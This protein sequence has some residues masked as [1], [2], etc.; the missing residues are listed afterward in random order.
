MVQFSLQREWQLPLF[1][2]REFFCLH[3]VF[4]IVVA[5]KDRVYVYFEK[6]L[7]SCDLTHSAVIWAGSPEPQLMSRKPGT[8]DRVHFAAFSRS[9]KFSW[10]QDKKHL[11]RERKQKKNSNMMSKSR[12][13]FQLMLWQ[14][15]I[16]SWEIKTLWVFS[17]QG[18][19][20]NIDLFFIVAES[21]YYSS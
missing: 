3:L 17:L 15:I 8:V 14:N 11:S 18:Y 16:W 1:I 20:K 21:F 19:G 4:W 7:I 6:V 2:P 13:E 5:K 9:K 12:P 10:K